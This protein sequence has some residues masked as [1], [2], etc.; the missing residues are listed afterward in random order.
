MDYYFTTNS[1]GDH[2]LQEVNGNTFNKLGAYGFLSEN[3]DS[4]LLKRENLYL[5][6]GTDS[7]QI[8]LYLLKKGI[9]PESEYL[10][11]ETN[12][13]HQEIN[14]SFPDHPQLHLCH[15]H[16]WKQK[17]EELGLNLHIQSKSA[18]LIRSTGASY[19]FYKSYPSL[20]ETVN[21]HYRSTS[22]KISA[23]T[24][25]FEFYKV[26][27][28][29]LA[30]N[31]HNVTVLEDQFT[32][33]TALL[34]GAAPS[35]DQHIEWIQ[36]NQEYLY[37]FAVSRLAEKL[38]DLG[39]T[40]DFIVTVDPK[41]GSFYLGKEMFNF[42]EQSILIN[43]YH[44]NPQLLSQWGGERL[45]IGQRYPWKTDNNNDGSAQTGS[46]VSNAALD[47]TII[48]GFSQILL[49]G[50]DFCFDSKGYTHTSDTG[51]AIHQ[52]PMVVSDTAD[53]LVTNNY[54]ETVETTFAFTIA[55]E[56]FEKTASKLKKPH[57]TISN[58][59]GSSIKMRGVEYTPKEQITLNTSSKT[60]HP[61][62]PKQPLEQYYKNCLQEL[63]EAHKQFL[64]IDRI[65][66]SII[67]ENK[68]LFDRNGIKNTKVE[69]KI[70]KLEKRVNSKHQT[71]LHLIKRVGQR[72]IMKHLHATRKNQELWTHNEVT[73][74]SISYYKTLRE[75]IEK[76]QVPIKDATQRL[77]SR[78]LELLP[79][80]NAL[81]NLVTQW[82]NDSQPRRALF[83]KQSHPET[84][85][86]LSTDD[87]NTIHEMVDEFNHSLNSNLTETMGENSISAALGNIINLANNH[88]KSRLE[89]LIPKLEEHPDQENSP[90]YIVLCEA[91]ILEFNEKNKEAFSTYATLLGYQQHL[92]EEMTRL[93]L[94]RVSTLSIKIKDYNNA[95]IALQTLS[96]VYNSDYHT[97]IYAE[98][99]Y[100]TGNTQ[101]A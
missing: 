79:Q 90:Y 88:N 8:P 26:G 4:I 37:I 12:E 28:T 67:Q 56:E 47:S 13:L 36:K 77:N 32:D 53:K 22:G 7:G 83:W 33:K 78:Q 87:Q 16:N 38:H 82:H 65:F 54:G 19:N 63:K 50:V 10:F 55:S 94:E 20:H 11:I 44:S 64:D 2:Y 1:Y 72:E 95:I 18:N 57:Q 101:P 40:P 80:V 45:F 14:K 30:E 75:T 71:L 68:K 6:V 51:A 29:N 48:M 84:Y 97:P 21:Q 39:I 96:E 81:P 59:S 86:N 85:K 9:P 69:T 25:P 34:I 61:I 74:S 89:Q 76:I 62:I 58:L 27:F 31:Q 100:L 66:R 49:A 99:L 35:L 41:I 92:T 52:A 15:E 23:N 3:Y 60:S 5:I 73:S 46:T 24:N 42:E 17:S 98:L 70:V 43:S 93:I 91:L